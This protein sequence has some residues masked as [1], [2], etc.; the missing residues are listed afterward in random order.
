MNYS[1][2]PMSPDHRKPVIDIYNHYIEKS[3]AA[4]PDEPV[5]YAIFDRFLDMTTGYPSLVVRTDSGEIVGFAF[6]RSFLPAA[7]FS[8]TAEITYFILPEHTHRGLGERILERFEAE[9]SKAGVDNL[10]ASV[11]SRNRFSLEFHGKHGFVECGRLKNVGR[12]FGEDFDVVWMQK[13]IGGTAP[14]GR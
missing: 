9:A 1:L 11:S 7:T 10:I 3:W 6:L 13:T 5:D 2:E 8:R 14:P 12:K 4:Y